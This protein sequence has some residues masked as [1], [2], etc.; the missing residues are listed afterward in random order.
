MIQALKKYPDLRVWVRPHPHQIGAV[1]E[2]EN[3][4][5]EKGLRNFLVR[6]NTELYSEFE[7][8]DLV[9]TA[10]S[11]VATEACDFGLPVILTHP[12]AEAAFAGMIDNQKIFYCSNETESINALQVCTSGT[13]VKFRRESIC[14]TRF[15]KYGKMFR[16]NI[17]RFNA[18]S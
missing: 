3:A 8:I 10:F 14:A 9:I 15:R 18:T 6:S 5:R 16:L 7:Q 11:T 13:E 12:N 17:F 2:I 1:S 4:V